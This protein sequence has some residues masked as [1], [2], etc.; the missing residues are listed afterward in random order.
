MEYPN[1]KLPRLK[2]FDYSNPNY[3]FVT[4]CTHS[5]EHLFGKCGDLNLLG[6]IAEAQLSE[7]ANHYE[8][9]FVDKFVVMPNHI[10]AI[11]VIAPHNAER[12]RPFPTLSSIVGQYK[13]GV[14]RSA[15]KISPGITIWQKSFHDHVIRGE[16][17]YQGIRQYIDTNP[18]TWE[19]DCFYTE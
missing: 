2:G 8:H 17:D 9:V 7:L 1:R 4:I 18:L 13:A 11:I 3:Y 14:S 5:R 15:R 16:H 19:D 10:H 12:S 6:K